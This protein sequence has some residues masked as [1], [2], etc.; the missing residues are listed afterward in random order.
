MDPMIYKCASDALEA[1]GTSLWTHV[2]SKLF[3]IA[4]KGLPG[5]ARGDVEAMQDLRSELQ[6]LCEVAK[7]LGVHIVVDAKYSW[8]R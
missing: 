2:D 6:D 4:D 8:F 5:L 7:K 3:P 1:R